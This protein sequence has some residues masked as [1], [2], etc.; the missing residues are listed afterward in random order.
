MEPSITNIQAARDNTSLL[1]QIN[2]N[3]FTFSF[4]FVYKCM[5]Y[6]TLELTD[7]QAQKV[8]PSKVLTDFSIGL[9]SQQKLLSFSHCLLLNNANKPK[10]ATT[11]APAAT[12]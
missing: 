11:A 3:G 7:W 12:A 10:A 1:T 9:Y 2:K 6:K 8:C 5:F 4:S